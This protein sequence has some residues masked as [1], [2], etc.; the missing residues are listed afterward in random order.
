[1]KKRIPGLEV[2]LTNVRLSF[3]SL[4]E[5]IRNKDGT[6]PP[7]AGGKKKGQDKKEYG[8]V[9]LLDKVA[10]KNE[11]KTIK[12]YFNEHLGNVKVDFKNYGLKDADDPKNDRLDYGGYKGCYYIQAKNP[13]RPHLVDNENE[14]V[15]SDDDGVFYAGCYVNAIID[16][17]IRDVFF[18]GM[19]AGLQGVQ[20]SMTGDPFGGSKVAKLGDFKILPSENEDMDFES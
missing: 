5:Y 19:S 1:M 8:A 12:D 6:F 2:R 9:F 10:H 14:V 18:P 17:Y 11:I 3:P 13:K 7:Y 4:F 16:L 15:M 20:F